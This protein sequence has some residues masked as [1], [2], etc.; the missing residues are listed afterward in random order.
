MLSLVRHGVIF[1]LMRLIVFSYLSAS[2]LTI[3]RIDLINQFIG[4][5]NQLQISQQ[6]K[7]KKGVF[8]NLFSTGTI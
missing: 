1:R 4:K 8:E 7:T 5:I 3:E 2:K 6:I